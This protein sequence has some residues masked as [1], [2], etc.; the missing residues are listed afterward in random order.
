MKKRYIYPLSSFVCL[1]LLALVL[2]GAAIRKTAKRSTSNFIPAG[3]PDYNSM[4]SD[5]RLRI[6]IFWGYDH[7][8]DTIIKSLP[9]F[10]VL[11]GKRLYVNGRPISI[12]VGVITQVD[13]NPKLIFKSAL[14][15]PTV[16]VVI[17]S[18]HARYGNGPAFT[19]FTDIFK[20]GNG[21]LIEDRH[22]KP[23]KI[24]KA[25][26]EDLD[27]TIFPN[28]YKIVM[29]NCCDSQGHFRESWKRRFME[30]RSPID[31]LTVEYPVFNFYDYKRVSV[32]VQDLLSFSD[33][34]TIKQHYE[35][36][37]YKRK[38]KLIIDPIT[39]QIPPQ[40]YARAENF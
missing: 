32:L 39:Q 22:F 23:Y 12:E 25:T 31:L 38:N 6:A 28:K 37:T 5:G 27:A 14:E 16:D 15:D 8:R 24:T 2:N 34:K 3:S 11:N 4:F 18:G 30:C 13:N 21:D 17:Y 35:A 19:S 10:T 20:C 29:L 7:P 36:E 40:Y 26:S 33:W 9:L 1:L